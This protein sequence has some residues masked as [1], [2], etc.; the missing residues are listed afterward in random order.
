MHK[1]IST[2]VICSQRHRS[3][4]EPP[5]EKWPYGMV[6]S[7]GEEWALEAIYDD[8]GIERTLF[9]GPNAEGRAISA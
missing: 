5:C 2:E 3:T 8:G 6:V 9:M 7:R 4:K 1:L